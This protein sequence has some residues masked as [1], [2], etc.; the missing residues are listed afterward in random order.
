MS[1]TNYQRY[2]GN[3]SKVIVARIE[4]PHDNCKEV[5]VT[6]NGTPVYVERPAKIGWCARLQDWLEREDA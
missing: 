6:W 1:E 4:T 3:A 5:R 2:F